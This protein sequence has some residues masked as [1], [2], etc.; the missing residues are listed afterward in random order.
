MNRVFDFGVA[1]RRYDDMRV[2]PV[3]LFISFLLISFPSPA[4]F[5]EPIDDFRGSSITNP[6]C[7]EFTTLSTKTLLHGF[8]KWR[9]KA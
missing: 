8:S 5:K 3:D 6:L 2:R 9:F 7:P 1:L 4:R